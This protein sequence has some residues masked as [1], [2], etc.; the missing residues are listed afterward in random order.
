MLK[1]LNAVKKRPE[2]LVYL[3]FFIFTLFFAVSI[4]F[5]I[6]P[7]ET[8]HYNSIQY[9]ANNSLDPAL[10][11]QDSDF[12]LGSIVTDVS[13]LY[14]YLMS[15]I[16]RLAETV[17]VDTVLAL[18]FVNILLGIGSLVCLNYIAKTLKITKKV[19]LAAIFLIA[20]I[21][22]FMFISASIN[23]DNLVIFMSVLAVAITLSLREKFTLAK[24]MG[25]LAIVFLGPIVKKAFLAV[26][27]VIGAYILY[28]LFKNRSEAT[29]QI[30]NLYI[31]NKAKLC[32]FGLILLIPVL[33]FSVK[34]G[35][36]IINYKSTEPK[37]D[38]VL[39]HQQCLE[40]PIYERTDNYNKQTVTKQPT[41]E[42]KYLVAWINLMVSRTYGIFGHKNFEHV[43]A[44]AALTVI[45]AYML[46]IFF[47]RKISFKSFKSTIIPVLFF[48]YMAALIY[49]NYKSYVKR[50]D[51]SLAVQGRYALPVLLPFILFVISLYNSTLR[52]KTY[53]YSLI[54][55]I[56]IFSI[57]SGPLYILK[58]IDPTWFN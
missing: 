15:F 53:Q 24:I 30:K 43:S 14:Y 11:R 8:H 36:N 7:D 56:I 39:T 6:A 27:V 29:N 17:N 19:R 38:K 28:S 5:G 40:N 22:M 12:A 4:K 33:M 37:C 46:I 48:F 47:F 49:T 26:S 35:S 54:A 18:K 20:S 1:F 2:L 21:P 25:L 51:I 45:A 9:Y 16:Y 58:G 55:L 32:V 50:G 52:K 44:V 23:Y 42:D 41:S 57:V 34:Y 3:Y 13:Y 31:K 10:D